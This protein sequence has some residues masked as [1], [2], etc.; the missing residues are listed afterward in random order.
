MRKK[1]EG[2]T[3]GATLRCVDRMTE[4]ERAALVLAPRR[5]RPLDEKE[6]AE[7]AALRKVARK[8]RKQEIGAAVKTIRELSSRLISK[9]QV[10]DKSEFL[11][12]LLPEIILDQLDQW[13]D[14]FYHPMNEFVLAM[15]KLAM[16]KAEWEEGE[17]HPEGLGCRWSDPDYEG[18]LQEGH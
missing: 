14:G 18:P 16:E 9:E 13:G 3:N 12:K 2:N 8:R 5:N 1:Q 11:N 6:R 15:Q 10:F 17:E 4:D 7:L